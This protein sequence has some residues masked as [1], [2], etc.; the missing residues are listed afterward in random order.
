[1]INAVN[2]LTHTPQTHAINAFGTLAC[3][4][5]M[6]AIDTVNTLTCAPQAHAINAAN[7][8]MHIP[9]TCAIKAIDNLTCAQ[10]CMPLMSSMPS[11]VPP[12][13]PQ[14]GCAMAK[15][16]VAMKVMTHAVIAV[17]VVMA[18]VHTLDTLYVEYNR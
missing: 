8:P 2:A 14:M 13:Y 12:Q 18:T 17:V 9:Q 7:A 1:M 10:K 5:Q 16:S 6:H 15:V 11:H 4:P 3:T